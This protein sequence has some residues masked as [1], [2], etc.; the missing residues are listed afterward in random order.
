MWIIHEK[1]FSIRQWTIAQINNF[2]FWS[3]AVCNNPCSVDSKLVV[4]KLFSHTGK[5]EQTNPSYFW[6]P[7]PILLFPYWW[8]F[9]GSEDVK[10]HY[11]NILGR[12]W[13]VNRLKSPFPGDQ[14]VRSAASAPRDETW[15]IRVLPQPGL[16]LST[17]Y[18][19]YWVLS[20]EQPQ[21]SP[22]PLKC[23]LEDF[24]H[25]RLSDHQEF[26]WQVCSCQCYC[27]IL[28]LQHIK[29][30]DNNGIIMSA[31]VIHQ[32]EYCLRVKADD[33]MIIAGERRVEE[34][35]EE[36]KRNKR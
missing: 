16:Q 1:L 10:M 6:F 32:L 4:R 15:W 35:R 31:V 19:D 18:W 25:L 33:W 34:E 21:A 30:P 23:K 20:T 11:C 14:S 24:A 5:K 17:E 22:V 7:I 9:Q 29:I 26:I 8:V 13:K 36:R 3:F 27:V 2:Q 12:I 28:K